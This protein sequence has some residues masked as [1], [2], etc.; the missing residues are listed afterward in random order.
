MPRDR[1]SII[2]VSQP[3]SSSNFERILL[4]PRD[5]GFAGAEVP[6]DS[7]SQLLAQMQDVLQ[8]KSSELMLAAIWNGGFYLWRCGV[9]PD[10]PTGFAKA[11]ALLLGGNA[12]QKLQEVSDAIASMQLV[13]SA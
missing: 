6:L 2:A 1:T 7:T 9:C 8:G 13:T 10:L 5:Y 3:G 11:Q 12:A 4:H